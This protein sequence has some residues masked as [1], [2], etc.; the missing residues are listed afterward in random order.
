MRRSSWILGHVTHDRVA[1]S[2][3]KPFRAL[4]TKCCSLLTGGASNRRDECIVAVSEGVR[5]EVTKKMR[6]GASNAGTAASAPKYLPS[7]E[8]RHFQRLNA[9]RSFCCFHRALTMVL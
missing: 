6:R 3:F 9:S 8:C 7:L 2:V 1:N 4:V 5:R